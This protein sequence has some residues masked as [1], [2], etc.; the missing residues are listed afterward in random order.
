M[1]EIKLPSIRTGKDDKE[2]IQNISDTYARLKKELEY[3]LGGNLEAGQNYTF[4]D[5]NDLTGKQGGTTSQFYHLSLALYNKLNNL[6]T[7]DYVATSGDTM[8]GDLKLGADNIGTQYGAG[9]DMEIIYDGTNGVIDTSLV[10]ASDLVLKCGTDKTFVLNETVYDDLQFAVSTGK[11]PAANYPDWQ[12]FTTNTSEYGFAVNEYIDMQANEL[13]HWWKEGSAADIHCHITPKDANS[14][15]SNRY[16]KFTVYVAYVGS[17]SIW[18]ETSFSAELTIPT[19]TA[20]MKGHYLDM[21]DLTL[22][23][24]KIGTQVKVRV[25]RIAATGGTEYGSDVFITQIGFHLQ[26]DT[27]G[28]RQE[29][30][31]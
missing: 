17:D 16:A 13:A 20:A 15:G 8:S 31:K 27:M 6:N 22:T 24:L 30:T 29:A 25:K 3:L 19:G 14:T 12:A 11:A 28:S 5:H 4:P 2:T 18:T 21:G 1:P 10:T 9:T 23:S 26:K 7:D